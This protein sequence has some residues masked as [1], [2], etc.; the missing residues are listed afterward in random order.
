MQKPAKK[1]GKWQVNSPMPVTDSALPPTVTVR[2]DKSKRSKPVTPPPKDEEEPSGNESDGSVEE[3]KKSVPA[4]QPR[5][6]SPTNRGK[7]P[8][9]SPSDDWLAHHVEQME[10]DMMNVEPENLQKSVFLCGICNC[11]CNVGRSETEER[12]YIMCKGHCRFQFTKDFND[13]VQIHK[14]ARELLSKRFRPQKGGELPRCPVHHEVGALTVP[15]KS[16][17]QCE[18]IIGQLFFLCNAKKEKGGPCH[19]ADGTRC[20]ICG[21]VDDN[22]PAKQYAARKAGMEKLYQMNDKLKTEKKRRSG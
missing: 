3:I 16:N 7:K 2:T 18:A 9:S 17:Q 8:P 5:A 20:I 21:S 11:P 6:T 13:S 19:N 4:G 1:K 10:R 12:I 22:F 14:M 15:F